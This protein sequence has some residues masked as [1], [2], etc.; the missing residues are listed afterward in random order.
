[1]KLSESFDES[2][3]LFEKRVSKRPVILDHHM[4]TPPPI[5]RHNK[6]PQKT[7]QKIKASRNKKKGIHH[8]I[9]TLPTSFSDL[10]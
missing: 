9:Q 3:V 8:Y 5:P 6:T 1:M 7:P 4:T 2:L 10:I